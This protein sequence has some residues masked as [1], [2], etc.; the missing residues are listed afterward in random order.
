MTEE[1]IN[2]PPCPFTGMSEARQG[3]MSVSIPVYRGYPNGIRWPLPSMVITVPREDDVR[4]IKRLA[5]HIKEEVNV[6][7]LLVKR[8]SSTIQI[9]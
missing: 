4:A 2:P 7:V 6:K 3:D 8:D 9:N 1:R 5:N